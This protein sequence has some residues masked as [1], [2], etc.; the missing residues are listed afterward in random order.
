MKLNSE[1]REQ[2]GNERGPLLIQNFSYPNKHLDG[3]LA[4]KCR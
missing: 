4:Q 3:F 1:N 2:D